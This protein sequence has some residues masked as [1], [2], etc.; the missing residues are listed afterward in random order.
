MMWTPPEDWGGA[1]SMIP[2]PSTFTIK[3][4]A[5]KCLKR[6]VNLLKLQ[7]DTSQNF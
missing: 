5:Y 3:P 7:A 2:A 4:I 1:E 6:P